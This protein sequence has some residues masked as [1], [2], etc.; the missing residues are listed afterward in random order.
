[1]IWINSLMVS[2]LPSGP[3]GMS[4]VWKCSW[5]RVR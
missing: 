2:V 3:M 5:T 4:M 1:M